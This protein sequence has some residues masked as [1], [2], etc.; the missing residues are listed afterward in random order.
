M[1]SLES[2]LSLLIL[3]GVA[4]LVLG[5]LRGRGSPWLQHDNTAPKQ[6]MT[7]AEMLQAQHDIKSDARARLQEVRDEIALLEA[8]MTDLQEVIDG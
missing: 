7:A 6:L 4:E 5:S 3:C 2:Q 8:E 1:Q